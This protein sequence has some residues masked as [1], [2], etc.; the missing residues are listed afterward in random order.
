MLY[1]RK[2]LQRWKNTTD[3]EDFADLEQKEDSE[4]YMF[5]SLALNEVYYT[6]K[7]KW[8]DWNV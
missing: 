3:K 6:K 5:G 4:I 8:N 7:I 2:E 1:I